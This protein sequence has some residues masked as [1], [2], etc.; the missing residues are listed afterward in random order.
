MLKLIRRSLR[1]RLMLVAGGAIVAALVLFGAAAVLLV[2]GELRG[3]LDNALRQRALDVAEVAVSAPA[4]LDSPGALESPASGRQIAVEVLDARGRILARSLS[5]GAD[6]FP[7]DRLARAALDSGRAGFEDLRLGSAPYRMYAAPIAQ[8]GGPAAGGAVLVGSDTSD[9]NDTIGRLGLV[10]TLTGV[11]VALIAVLAAGLLTGRALGPLRRLAVGGEE[12][13]QTADASKRLPDAERPDEIGQLTGVLNRMLESL[14]AAR[15]NERRFLADASHELRTP[16][17]ALLG[18]VE[19]LARHGSTPELVADL[20]RDAGRL[21]RL[22]D[23]L[24]V[25]ERA[26]AAGPRAEVVELR[27][28]V[29]E[30]VAEGNPRVRA[31][32]LQPV[33]VSA[34]RD[35]LARAVGNLIE[36]ALVHGPPDGR[37]S[38]T[39]A[40]AGGRA[41]ISVR[42]EGPGPDPAHHHRLFERFWRAPEAAGRPGSGLG[43]PIVA[44]VAARHHG[45]VRVDGPTFTLELP[46]LPAPSGARE[47]PRLIPHA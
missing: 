17:T 26:A 31:Q 19:Y 7:E 16:V 12:I 28:L 18:N 8:A 39:V 2:R 13:E 25:L 22:V 4:I 38:V 34:D 47:E 40:R 6:L 9:I 32:E 14:E 10:V 20:K 11:G 44:A 36:N 23:D 46:A 21:A 30:L 35:A 5:L 3:S 45:R 43:L 15:D 29:S 37:V 33:A 24:L 42:D 41:L 27:N 1:T